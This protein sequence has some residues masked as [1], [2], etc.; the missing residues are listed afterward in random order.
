MPLSISTGL[1]M[2]DRSKTMD[3]TQKVTDDFLKEINKYYTSRP[4]ALLDFTN[5]LY[6]D[7]NQQNVQRFPIYY[8]VYTYPNC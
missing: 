7:K 6:L 1:R 4:T 8:G 5:N 2:S 3:I